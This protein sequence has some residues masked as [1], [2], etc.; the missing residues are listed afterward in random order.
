MNY[1][2]KIWINIPDPNNMPAIPQG[3]D[4]LAIFDAD[5]MNRIEEGIAKSYT[6]TRP[7]TAGGT[8]ASTVKGALE[9]LGLSYAAKITTGSYDGTGTYGAANP[10][11][12]TFDFVPKF[13]SISPESQSYFGRWTYNSKQLM[14]DWTF[15]NNSGTVCVA[16]LNDKTLSWYHSGEAERQLNHSGEKYFYVAIG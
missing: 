12:L 15:G 10:T 4:E 16:E 3:Q 9:N 11:T 1:K 2:K 7:I 5:N 6:V 8:G 14:V 13:I